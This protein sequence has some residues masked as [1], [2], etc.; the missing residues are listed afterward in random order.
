MQTHR[1]AVSPACPRSVRL[2]LLPALFASLLVTGCASSLPPCD[3]ESPALQAGEVRR[4]GGPASN[5]NEAARAAWRRT[6][7]RIDTRT[8]F[9]SAVFAY[10]SFRTD[11]PMF[12]LGFEKPRDHSA[13]PYCLPGD[14]SCPGPAIDVA[15]FTGA[16]DDAPESVERTR[17][18]MR[19]R[20]FHDP[21]SLALTHILRPRREKIETRDADEA[22]F[23]YNVYAGSDAAPW[24][25]NRTVTSTDDPAWTRDGWRALRSFASELDATVQ[26]ERP[27]HII[28]LATGWNT[29]EYESFLDFSFWARR[30]A[31]DFENHRSAFRPLY[32]GIAWE[33]AWNSPFW[34]R[35]PFA[36]WSTKGND[37]DE[38]GYGWA[39][40][41]VNDIVAPAA[42]K[43]N[44]QLVA[45]GHSF[46]SRVVLT[47]IFTKRI[48]QTAKPAAA[49]PLVAIGI[50]AAFPIGRF[51]SD[52]GVEH[53]YLSANQDNAVVVITASEKD[54]ATAT[55]SMGSGYIGGPAGLSAMRSTSTYA[56]RIALFGAND[57]GQPGQ[58]P[59]T[60]VVSLYDVTPFVNCELPGTASGA[61]SAV[62][63]A[64]M[65]T[66]L[67]TIIRSA[68]R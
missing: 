17:A 18:D 41:L 15:A 42:L 26:R 48:L 32:I 23:V 59:R 37:A 29:E 2:L 58:A 66:F 14:A 3:G 19:D 61:H 28:V 27:T 49:A 10:D 21:R 4:A 31:K 54:E 50:E 11:V 43:A 46:G 13:R 68:G 8:E 9:H 12:L 65:G 47:S 25:P 30:L 35:L 34:S 52:V 56:R 45:I 57:A 64:E 67:G 60:D 44:A 24:C 51:V 7:D 20:L 55:I 63:S 1:D 62:Y 6:V 53:Q 39:S 22:C 16:A 5:L 38:A 33:S 36:S 40:F